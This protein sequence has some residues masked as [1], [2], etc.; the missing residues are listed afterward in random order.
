MSSANSQ[1]FEYILLKASLENYWLATYIHA[2]QLTQ[3]HGLHYACGEQTGHVGP[4][5]EY[6]ATPTMIEGLSY[7][8]AG[9]R[10]S[11]YDH[12]HFSTPHQ[13]FLLWHRSLLY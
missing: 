12:T 11:L 2:H 13:F 4:C 5:I 1:I 7:L 8:R 6:K 9:N 10:Q 3:S